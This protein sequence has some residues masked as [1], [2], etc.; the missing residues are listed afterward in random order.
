[1]NEMTNAMG[2]SEMTAVVDESREDWRM[3]HLVVAER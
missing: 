2:V 3:M 1:M